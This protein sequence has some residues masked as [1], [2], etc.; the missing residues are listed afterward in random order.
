MSPNTYENQVLS[1]IILIPITHEAPRCSQLHPIKPLRFGV[2]G[3][4]KSFRSA[5]VSKD[6]KTL[7]LQSRHI[8]GA[9]PP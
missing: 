1:Y 2:E 7:I 6:N 9:L 3:R 8:F 5:L 4:Q